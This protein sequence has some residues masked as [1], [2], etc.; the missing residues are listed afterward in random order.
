MVKWL[1]RY[2]IAE[3]CA[4]LATASQALADVCNAK[5]WSSELL[6]ASESDQVL[7]KFL[8]DK[9]AEGVVVHDCKHGSY[10]CYEQKLKN[11]DFYTNGA[12]CEPFSKQ[13]NGKGGRDARSDTSKQSVRFVKKNIDQ[14][15]SCWSKSKT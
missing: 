6:Y 9:C 2:T 3:D 5:G 4:G 8:S 15:V 11:V 14:H 7:H 1:R 10:K 13:G 12:S